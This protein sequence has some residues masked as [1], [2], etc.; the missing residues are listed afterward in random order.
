MQVHEKKKKM[1]Y[2]SFKSTHKSRLSPLLISIRIILSRR[3]EAL[4]TLQFTNVYNTYIVRY[5][6]CMG[7][8]DE[9]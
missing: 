3:F 1:M 5:D 4:A 7:V 8:T 6:N 9:R 2:S